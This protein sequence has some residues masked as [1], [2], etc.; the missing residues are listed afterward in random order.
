M[1]EPLIKLLEEDLEKIKLMNASLSKSL[2][3]CKSIN[4]KGSFAEKEFEKM[5]VLTSR[6]SRLSDFIMQKILRTIDKINLEDEGTMRDRLNRAEKNNLI[7]SAEEFAVIRKLRNDISHEYIP[8]SM[9][10]IFRNVILYS[11][12]L[13]DSCK[14][15]IKYSKKNYF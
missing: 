12:L 5:D 6:F 7:S 1:N 9:I 11:P 15:I 14:K 13:N 10:E 3:V 8:E 4:T 2:R